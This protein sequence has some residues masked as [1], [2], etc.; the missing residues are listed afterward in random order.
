M[1][2]NCGGTGRA[3][4][5]KSGSYGLTIPFALACFVKND[6]WIVTVARAATGC[7]L[8]WRR[9]SCARVCVGAAHAGAPSTRAASVRLHPGVVCYRHTPLRRPRSH[10]AHTPAG[11]GWLLRAGCWRTLCTGSCKRDSKF[12]LV[13][14]AICTVSLHRRAG[15]AVRGCASE[16][17]VCRSWLTG[18]CAAKAVVCPGAGSC[19]DRTAVLRYNRCQ[20]LFLKRWLMAHFAH[21][22]VHDGWQAETRSG[23]HLHDQLAPPS[24]P[25]CAGTR[26]SGTWLSISVVARMR[27]RRCTDLRPALRQLG[28]SAS[29]SRAGWGADWRGSCAY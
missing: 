8:L 27:S 1:A 11:S 22:R 26:V 6:R 3:T 4:S 18:E 5:M 29:E 7:V 17:H 2:W 25:C 28:E 12:E 14:E 15:H 10:G 20:S 23:S 24:A 9:R 16:V 13:R 19:T 21:G